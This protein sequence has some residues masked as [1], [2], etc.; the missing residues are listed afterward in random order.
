MASGR[1][2]FGT[3]TKRSFYSKGGEVRKKKNK[4]CGKIMSS[5]RKVTRYS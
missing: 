3:L 5:R 4:G 2:Q 1:S